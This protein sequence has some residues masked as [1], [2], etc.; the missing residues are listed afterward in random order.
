MI[1]KPIESVVGGL[2][3]II[4]KNGPSYPT[5]APYEV[6][7]ELINS[8][9]ADR[10]TAAAI[11]HFLVSGLMVSI[12]FYCDSEQISASIKQECSLNKRM[13]DRLALILISLYSGEHRREWKGKDR[14]GLRSFLREKC[15]CNW[16]GFAIWDAGNGTVDCH[17]KA[18]I[19]LAPTEEIAN[20]KELAQ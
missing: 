8:G 4:D 13:A 19:V 3:E 9:A 5:D 17:Y 16:K 20:D 11:L 7:L 1:E 14:E 6:Y 15:S 10:K 12:D 2:K 18:E